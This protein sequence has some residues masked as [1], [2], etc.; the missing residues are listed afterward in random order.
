MPKVFEYGRYVVFFWSNEEGEPVHVHIAVK[1]PTEHATKA[2]LT[3]SGGCELANNNGDIPIKDLVEIMQ[4]IALNHMYIC[5][6]WMQVFGSD[7]VRY[8][9]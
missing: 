8:H 5:Q 4:I 6:R 2:W 9:L 3:Q 7:C 1:R